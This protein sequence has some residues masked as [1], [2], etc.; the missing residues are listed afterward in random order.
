MKK[1]L[2]Q[3]LNTKREQNKTQI[4]TETEKN[5]L[6]RTFNCASKQRNRK[7]VNNGAQETR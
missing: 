2:C 7:T 4:E 3:C 6:K 5:Q 1:G